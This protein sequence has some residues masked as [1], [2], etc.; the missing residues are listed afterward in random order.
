MNDNNSSGS[1]GI[2]AL[3]LLGVAFVV[4]NALVLVIILPLAL[5]MSR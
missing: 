2:G 4:L 1:G 5:L 3:V